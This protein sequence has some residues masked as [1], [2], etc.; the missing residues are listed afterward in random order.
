MD[1]VAIRFMP[2]APFSLVNLVAGI[3]SV[4]TWSFLTGTL[5]GLIPSMFA[6]GLVGDAITSAYLQP[7][8]QSL[9]YI[10]F[11]IAVWVALLFVSQ[12]FAKYYQQQKLS[13]G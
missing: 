6:K 7:S 2:I 8:L 1:V 11:S 9:A 13:D 5:I 10:G 3:A 12:R 4:S